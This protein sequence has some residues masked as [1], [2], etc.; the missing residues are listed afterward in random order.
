MNRFFSRSNVLST[1]RLLATSAALSLHLLAL[2]ASAQQTT[3]PQAQPQAQPEAQ[4][5]I[6]TGRTEIKSAIASEFMA[7][8]ANP[9]ASA[10]A[11]QILAKGGTAVDAAIT[12]QLVLGLVEPQSSGIGGGAFMLSYRADDKQLSGYD[13]R[14]TAPQ[15]VDE[16]Y[17][18]HDGKP[19]SFIKAVIGGYSVGVP[20]V[21]RMME[22]AH[23]RDGKL[24]WAELFQPAIALAENGFAISPRLY[25]LAER[26]PMVAA[27]PAI[28][29]YLFAEDGK[30]LPVGHV[31][32]NP[33]YAATLKLL[34]QKGTKPFYEGEIAQAIV[35]AVR[36]D[37]EN[38]G[39]M[40][41]A[42]MASYSAK[43]RK[44]VCAAYFE[45]EVCGASAPSSGGTTVGAILGMLQHTPVQQFDI[46]S[47]ELTH[48]F[49]EASE[50]AFA[51][52]NTYAA[53]SDFVEVPTA[54]LVAPEYLAARAKLIDVEKAQPA[55]AGDPKAFAGKRV[56]A[57]SPE[58]P[59]TSHLSIVDQYG[60]AVSMT[61]S[62]ETGFGSR[63]LV[64]GFLLN[65]QLTDFSFVPHN[66]N[67][68]LVA[69]R[70]Q[71][72][73]RPRSSMSPTMV[74]NEDDSLRLIIGSPG[75]SRIIDYTARSIL[76]HL[77][78]G[79]P[80][81]EAIAAGN[82]GAIGYRVEV[83]P[84]TLNDEELKKLEAKGHKVV[85][86]DLNSGIH[87]IALKQG[88]LHGG[89]D[90]RREGSAVGR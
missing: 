16:N 24:P 22:L 54:A 32:K 62:I 34:A 15:A 44:P 28:T 65:N 9:H 53:D 35:D 80:I 82:I 29:A 81:A 39:V 6:A 18:M 21:M 73:K 85:R 90:T 43:I 23:K 56:E 60:N 77:T 78:K 33:E 50:L 86:R 69:N 36:N 70:I 11:E 72:G 20:G 19:M 31:L 37:P 27:R 67:K 71:A 25:K 51:D 38:P 84:D 79:M 10:A 87:G 5:E 76:Y 30:P 12:A 45:F 66:A 64:K 7:V 17:F 26:L 13:G 49:I 42:D 47:A 48:L 1:S 57:K 74:F 89:A 8:T 75:G 3:Q 2:P 83:E 46:G 59:N 68:E 61:T 52:R 55:K 40:T 58:M 63:L 88:K 4:P 14:E 41:M